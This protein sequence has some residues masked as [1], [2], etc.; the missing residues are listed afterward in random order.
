VT[1]QGH[2]VTT[3]EEWPAEWEI[4]R[5][6]KTTPLWVLAQ[7]ER[8]GSPGGD[9]VIY[10]L[11]C[12]ACGHTMHAAISGLT[13]LHPYRSA[14]NGGLT[15]AVPCP[16]HRWPRV[17]DSDA[18]L[19]RHE[20]AAARLAETLRHDVAPRA[21]VH[22][23]RFHHRLVTSAILHCALTRPGTTAGEIPSYVREEFAT[24]ERLVAQWSASS[25]AYVR[26]TA[27]ILQPRV[28]RYRARKKDQER[29]LRA[30]T[31]R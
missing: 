17:P 15:R 16:G 20:T 23:P 11:R 19:P 13:T 30:E 1:G 8:E 7:A 26:Q 6:A 24:P 4:A 31:V 27:E 29:T 2:T 25:S 3:W 22:A 14:Q 12:A 10:T 5:I 21:F 28:E 9:T 18:L